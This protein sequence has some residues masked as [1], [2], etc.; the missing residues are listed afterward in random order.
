MVIFEQERKDGIAELVSS[1]ASIV[2]DTQLITKPTPKDDKSIAALLEI[3]NPGQIDLFYLNCI[4]A[5]TGWNKND[6]VFD[7]YETWRAR[8]TPVDKPFNFM[9]D[10]NDIIGHITGSLAI[11]QQGQTIDDD[12]ELNN[13]PD[14]FDLLVSSVIYKRWPGEDRTEEIAQ[15]IKEIGEDKWFVSM[16]CLFPGFDYALIDENGNQHIIKRE[17][18]TAFLTKYLRV[19]EGTGNYQGY[20]I[21]RLL[22]DFTFS[23]KGLVDRPANPRSI[24]FND[25]MIFNGSEASVNMFT[26]TEGSNTM[27]DE[28]DTKIS[29]LEKQIAS[30]VEENKTLKTQADEEVK[31]VSYTHLTLPTNREV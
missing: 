25:S 30:L 15:L 11:S 8:A 31:P 23:G 4:L 9:H 20:K 3:D 19:Y 29:D 17:E 22:R 7:K 18:S 14:D 13:L 1:K 28:K 5:S 24:I 27:T 16:E 12:V 10:G 21:G 6:D 26:E 2:F